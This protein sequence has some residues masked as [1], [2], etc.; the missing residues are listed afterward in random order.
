MM[1]NPLKRVHIMRTSI[2]ILAFGILWLTP[3]TQF[4]HPFP[5]DKENPRLTW[6]EHRRK[7][8]KS[9]ETGKTLE[10][11]F[12]FEAAWKQ[13]RT[14]KELVYQAGV[15]YAQ[16]RD[17]AKA[18]QLLAYTKDDI[19][20]FPSARYKYALALKQSGQY[21]EAARELVI[22]INTY[23]G[24]DRNEVI[25]KLQYELSG[26]SLGIQMEAAASAEMAGRPKIKLDHLNENINSTGAD[27]APV[28][29]GND[30]LY[31]TSDKKGGLG[32][33]RSQQIGGEWRASDMPKF[34]L[35]QTLPFGNGCFA[36]DASR[37]Y[38]SQQEVDKKGNK[39]S[40]IYV[41]KRG[42]GNVGWA[43]PMRLRNYINADGATTTHPF[44]THQDGIETLYFSSNR[45]NG[46]GGMDLWAAT[47][48]I[49][50]PDIDFTVPRNLGKTVNSSADEV[51]PFYDVETEMLYFAS[52]GKQSIGGLDIFKTKNIGNKNWNTP[53]NMGL[54]YNSAADDYYFIQNKTKN[55]G[56]F[57]SN[58]RFAGEKVTTVD[59]DIFGFS[60]ESSQP[61]QIKGTIV[62]KKGVNQSNTNT[63]I[64]LYE[65]RSKDDY[66]LL[67]A[68]TVEKEAYQMMIMPNKMYR[69]EIE[70]ES[71]A[72][73]TF[74]FATNDTSKMILKNFILEPTPTLAAKSAEKPMGPAGDWMVDVT[75]A[76]G[77]T[78]KGTPKMG[79]YYRVQL[80]TTKN[81]DASYRRR[82][83]RVE[84]FG[85]FDIEWAGNEEKK[86]MIGEFENLAKANQACKTIQS[87][88]FKTAF[89][90]KYEN[91]KRVK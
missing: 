79:T 53:E 20:A 41:I 22:A 10:A 60:I 34:P 68:E 11:A 52:N 5:D 39:F 15:L 46:Q 62:A 28:L 70:S 32:I 90:V 1:N 76:D 24:K 27:F 69:L 4:A 59:D 81:L 7:A 21:D 87:K 80:A 75:D 3:T 67:T 8:E 64:S 36:P 18:V 86:L 26:C 44:V 51:T 47:R 45:R 54:P 48:E 73:L 12:H 63:T 9:I 23:M 84:S 14:Q 31:F 88:S 25:E 6:K 40:A 50:S 30:I 61:L 19:K 16:A 78:N 38:Y 2:S 82:L 35:D 43:Q 83:E 29:F 49:S 74:D 17:Y 65:K 58:R 42:T 91:G 13:K 71:Y 85:R 37:F 66:R 77:I 55:G 33:H 89:V 72:T 56:F 57:T